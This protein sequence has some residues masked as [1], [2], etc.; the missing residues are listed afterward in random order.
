MLTLREVNTWKYCNG[1]EVK[2]V[3]GTAIHVLMRLGAATWKYCNGRG[4][5]AAPGTGQYCFGLQDVVMWPCWHLSWMYVE[6]PFSAAWVGL[7]RS[8]D[9][10]IMV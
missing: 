9:G 3:I 4:V 1:P 8:Q 7:V 10:C 6:V 2:A 5:K